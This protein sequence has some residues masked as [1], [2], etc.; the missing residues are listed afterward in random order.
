MNRH[1]PYGGGYENAGPRRGGPPGGGFGPDRSHRFQE[2]GGPPRGRGGFR[3]RGGGSYGGYG[4]GVMP[5]EQGPPQ[6]DMGGYNSYESAPPQEDDYQN[7]SY[8]SGMPGQFGPSTDASG[9][10]DQGYGDFEGALESL[11]YT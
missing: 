9:S 10:Y 11:H 4:G 6:G 2:R 5:Y 3:G 7:G 1:H 8:S